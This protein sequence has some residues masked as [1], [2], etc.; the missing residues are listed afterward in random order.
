MAVSPRLLDSG[1]GGGAAG[2]SVLG[3]VT[4]AARLRKCLWKCWVFKKAAKLS[5]ALD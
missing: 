1:R 5:P 4:A 2:V 3:V